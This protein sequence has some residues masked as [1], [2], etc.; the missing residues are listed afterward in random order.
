MELRKAIRGSKTTS[1][2]LSPRCRTWEDGALSRLSQNE[3]TAAVRLLH[4]DASR[5]EAAGSYVVTNWIIALFFPVITLG[6]YRVMQQKQ[7]FLTGGWPRYQMTSVPLNRRQVCPYTNEATHPR[8][9]VEGCLDGTAPDE[10]H[11]NAVSNPRIK[12]CSPTSSGPALSSARSILYPTSRL[13]AWRRVTACVVLDLG[14]QSALSGL[15][16][17]IRR[18]TSSFS[19][20]RSARA[21]VSQ[22]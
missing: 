10:T 1:A 2:L 9:S 22:R 3:S 19:L 13:Y 11:G 14:H 16:I 4:R 12:A 18:P 6:S 20:Y 21:A 17:S 5:P 8:C 7:P 15:P